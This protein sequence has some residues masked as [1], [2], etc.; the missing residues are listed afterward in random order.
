M[1]FLKIVI[2]NEDNKAIIYNS[3]ILENIL[4][5]SSIVNDK[6]YQKQNFYDEKGSLLIHSKFLKLCKFVNTLIVNF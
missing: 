5:L 1:D 2:D 4:N 6:N 3:N